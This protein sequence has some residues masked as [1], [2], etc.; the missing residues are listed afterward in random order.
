MMWGIPIVSVQHDLPVKNSNG[1]TAS[2]IQSTRDLY[3]CLLDNYTIFCLAAIP[4]Y[5]KMYP[6]F[7]LP[8]DGAM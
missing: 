7:V 5:L 3:L 1:A 8:M 6:G 2:D 4:C